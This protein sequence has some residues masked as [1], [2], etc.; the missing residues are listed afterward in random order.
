MI[1]PQI[2]AMS[3]D[4]LFSALDKGRQDYTG[5]INDQVALAKNYSLDVVAYE[6]ALG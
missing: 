2:L 1:A 5:Y 4:A 6:G 3:M